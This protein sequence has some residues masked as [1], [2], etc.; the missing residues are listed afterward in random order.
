MDLPS[1]GGKNRKHV[2]VTAVVAYKADKTPVTTYEVHEVDS[3][4]GSD[5][6]QTSSPPLSGARRNRSQVNSASSAVSG[7]SLLRTPSPGSAQPTELTW[8]SS[9]PGAPRI[10]FPPTPRVGRPLYAANRMQQGVGLGLDLGNEWSH[11]MS[12]ISYPEDIQAENTFESRVFHP[13]FHNIEPRYTGAGVGLGITVDNRPVQTNSNST[14]DDNTLVESDDD[15]EAYYHLPSNLLSPEIV[16]STEEFK[17]S[18]RQWMERRK[19]A[20]S[21]ARV[22]RDAHLDEENMGVEQE[23]GSRRKSV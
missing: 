1:P 7:S 5:K 15:S 9:P 18:L 6:E 22:E 8:S 20:A 16:M 11:T 14:I 13:H 3:D 21:D 17:D 12:T 19:R 10:P 23:Q 4:S 2:R